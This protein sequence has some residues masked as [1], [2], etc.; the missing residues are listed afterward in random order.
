MFSPNTFMPAITQVFGIYLNEIRTD[1][2][3]VRSFAFLIELGFLHG[4]DVL[5]G[6]N[7]LALITYE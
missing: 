4:R 3:K 1:F 2:V 6:Y 7:V 5:A